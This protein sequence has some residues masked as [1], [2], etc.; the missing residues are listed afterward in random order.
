MARLP[1][2][3]AAAGGGESTGDTSPLRG[4]VVGSG[5][6]LARRGSSLAAGAVEP[7]MRARNFCTAPR[8]ENSTTPIAGKINREFR[9]EKKDF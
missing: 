7:V 6:G 4:G 1:P 8:T 2:D 3:L 9:S 5:G